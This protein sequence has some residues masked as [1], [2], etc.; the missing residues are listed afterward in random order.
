MFFLCFEGKK[1][2]IIHYITYSIMVGLGVGKV[3]FILEVISLFLVLIC[4]IL[5]IDYETDGDYDLPVK[6]EGEKG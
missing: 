2:Y 4:W 6:D 1:A 3:E 5:Y